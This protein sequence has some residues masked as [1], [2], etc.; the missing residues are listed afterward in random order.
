MTGRKELRLNSVCYD[1]CIIG[2]GASGLVAA[3]ESSRRG[4]SCVVVEK[5]K[6]PAVKLYATGNG[7]CNLTN[8]TWEED[9][10]YENSFVDSVYDA[11]YRDTGLRPRNFVID[12]FKKLGVTTVNKN[13]YIYP[14][15]MQASTVVWSLVDAAKANGAEIRCPFKVENVICNTDQDGIFYEILGVSGKNSN[16]EDS[17]IYARKLILATG[18]ISQPELGAAEDSNLYNLIN[19]L[20]LTAKE[21]K[22][23]LCPVYCS[24]D[25]S[26]LAGVRT[27]A[28]V[29]VNGH[30][31]KGEV[32]FT[33][34]GLSGIVIFNMSYY[35][36]PG[37]TIHLSL[38]DISEDDFVHHF[39]LVK[40]KYP[41][42]SLTAFL[43]GYINDKLALYYKNA[44]YGSELKLCL[45]DVTEA[46]IRGLY[47][48]MNDWWIKIRSKADISSSQASI[49][50]I[51][52][53]DINPGTMCIKYKRFNETLY[54]VGEV[55]DVIGKCGGYNLT[56]AFVTG[57]LAGRNI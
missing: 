46:G 54:A 37:D 56:Y 36:N 33:E 18:G 38:L 40:S 11:L 45:V 48:D 28:V 43:N 9:S 55:T 14:R 21:F 44:F 30:S 49:G 26:A 53:D 4:L 16:A 5:N 47:Q 29:S 50:G 34:K 13:G 35:L 2:A 23:G 17:T 24:D 39:N 15:S 6:K 27:K 7:R 19:S 42:R 57:Y 31:E 12:Y 22:S 20:G 3:I 8:D 25:L 51:I 32:Q 10:Y 52:T 41:G 1:I